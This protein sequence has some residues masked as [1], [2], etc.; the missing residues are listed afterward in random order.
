MLSQAE[1]DIPLQQQILSLI[2]LTS[3]NDT[4][5]EE[6]ISFLCERAYQ[7]YGHV[8]GVCVFPRFV[9]HAVECLRR[10][11]SNRDDGMPTFTGIQ[12]DV[13]IVTVA[14]FPDGNGSLVDTLLSIKQSIAAGANEIDVVFPYQKY[15][16]GQTTDAIDFIRQCKAICGE[17]V[18]LKVILETGA[19]PSIL[20]LKQICHDVIIA[21]ADFLKTS[22]GKI[23]VG[24]TLEAAQVMLLVIKE[25][26]R[27][28]GF[29]ASGGIRELEQALHYIQLA[30]DIMG[31]S[32]VNPTTFRLGTSQLVTVLEE[33]WRK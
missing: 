13:R 23:S 3:L 9:A 12:P 19:I 6:S 1:N 24:A 27:P 14:N 32:W 10:L 21:G 26:N 11:A 20:Q 25:S 8:A 15:L 18:L 2:D 22:T 4:D 5:T 17:K 29:K 31:A 28:V 33:A 30:Q 16:S 7:K